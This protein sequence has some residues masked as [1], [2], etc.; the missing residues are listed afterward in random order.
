MTS[1]EWK[2][3]GIAPLE[4]TS[5]I[6]VEGG[7]IT[8]LTFVFDDDS[9]AKLTS[10]TYI[11]SEDLIG[12]WRL[13]DKY[14][15]FREDGTMRVANTPDDLSAPVDEAHPG[16]IEEWS[17]DG[18]VLIM[19]DTDPPT[20]AAWEFESDMECGAGSYL[21]KWGDEGRIKFR[22]IKE[23]CANRL[24]AFEM[25]GLAPLSP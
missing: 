23:P 10:V 12:E 8:T 9:L 15:I 4:G 5:E 13:A 18:T 16:V 21:V 7:K 17:Y 2:F 22:S 20:Y 25:A 14:I 3:L 1:R 24:V 6:T 19:Q 11:T